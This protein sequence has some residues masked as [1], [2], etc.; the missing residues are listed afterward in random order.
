[1]SDDGW[2]D[3]SNG[4]DGAPASPEYAG[5]PAGT[6]MGS[7]AGTPAGTPTGTPIGSPAGNPSGSSSGT[8]IGSPTM[9]Y[10][11]G[12][13][14]NDG[15]GNGDGDGDGNN[16][17]QEGT[18]GEGGEGEGGG[19]EEWI[20]Y[21]DDE[22]KTYY[23]NA[24][25]QET[26]WDLPE[27]ATVVSPP[28]PDADVD[29]EAEGDAD[30]DGDGEVDANANANAEAGVDADANFKAE[31]LGDD[32]DT[33]GGVGAGA[34]SEQEQEWAKYQDD[35]GR[36]Y[37]YNATTG[38]TQWDM[39]DGFVDTPPPGGGVGEGEGDAAVTVKEE[40]GYT[41][42]PDGQEEDG[43]TG[44]PAMDMDVDVDVDVGVGVGVEA[45]A[46]IK[47]EDADARIKVEDGKDIDM[48]MDEPKPQPQPQVDIKQEEEE[49][50]K[51]EEEPPRDSQEGK[52]EHAKNALSQAD[53]ILEPDVAEHAF[54]VVSAGINPSVSLVKGYTG[55][56]AICGILSKWLL[57]LK[58]A[59]AVTD[60]KGTSKSTTTTTSKGASQSGKGG[61]LNSITFSK[62]GVGSGSSSSTNKKGGTDATSTG[63][64]KETLSIKNATADSIRQLVEK[65]IVRTAKTNFTEEVQERMVQ[66][67][68][69]FVKFAR[70][71][72]EMM[73]HSRWRR[74][75][76]DLAGMPQHKNSPFLKYCLEEI[77]K[78][79]HHREIAKRMNQSDYFDVF[80]R[81]VVNELTVLG[82]LS[83]NGGLKSEPNQDVDVVE[84]EQQVDLDLDMDVSLSTSI[85]NIVNDLKRQCTSTEYTYIYVIEVLDELI[86]RAKVKSKSLSGPKALGLL[87][88]I[89]K[90][91][92]LREEIEEHMIKP[93]N[94]NTLNPLARKR[95]VDIALT[96][97]E[98]YQRQRRRI[99]L[100][101]GNNKSSNIGS[102]NG[103]QTNVNSSEKLRYSVESGLVSTLKKY[104]MNVQMDAKLVEQL[105]YNPYKD[106][107]LSAEENQKQLG[108]QL[109]QHS[110][111][112]QYL[113]RCLFLPGS[114]VK[115]PELKMKCSRLIALAVLATETELI[116]MIGD[117]KNSNDDNNVDDD[118]KKKVDSG[119]EYDYKVTLL[120][121]TILVGSQLCEQV[122]SIVKFA[123]TEEV[124]AV[125]STSSVGTQLSAQ[126][127][128]CGTVAQGFLMWAKKR[129][130][131][132]DF[133]SSAAYPY[134]APGIL[135]LL[136]II[137]NRHPLLRETVVD[138]AL[139]FLD[140]SN[141]ELSY[142]KMNTIRE[143]ALRLLLIIAS[144]GLAIEVFEK[145]TLKLKGKSS[146][147]PGMVRYFVGGALEVMRPPFSLSVVRSM[148]TMLLM[149]PCL[150][151]LNAVYFESSKKLAFKKVIQSFMETVMK[152]RGNFSRSI[153]KDR[154]ITSALKS[155][156]PFVN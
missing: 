54:T 24:T 113:L 128:K 135:S 118:E 119:K 120:S 148:G 141:S 19:G 6:P 133:I 16:Q 39:P 121:K 57:D 83:I 45:G 147:D 116:E 29:V 40:D 136:R 146:F 110:L 23:Y 106:K 105:L 134:T 144:K 138:S 81:M 91:E 145:V 28:L 90:W 101:R 73:E 47:V 15:D 92:R 36:D 89:Q 149:K 79:G 112:T 109:S 142:Q 17:E 3:N 70:F 9:N 60:K 18:S 30:G 126:C 55:Q 88:A 12:D 130:S 63:T 38:V 95:R 131:N 102:S 33:D 103:L 115:S 37:Y 31:D 22:G 64:D 140:H 68:D 75:L 8:P 137:S 48:E 59:N 27:G 84:D 49:P 132:S 96:S 97:S 7:P 123:V 10:E 50:I 129:I 139:I 34:G 65:V 46:S 11:N 154:A 44:E 71:A 108:H 32:K 69:T 25:T 124:S 21:Q 82:K 156:Y 100:S 42:E 93:V 76:I 61:A 51:Q 80:H 150:G 74:L 99:R 35:D 67:K 20:E 78:R 58:V 143:Q 85:E 52:L 155:S 117:D 26:A 72:K 14:D 94:G 127:I 153:N 13:G 111:G 5:T 104:S 152:E 66:E 1:M 86:A 122:E 4:N 41:G 114:R 107:H 53:A 151:A 2:N 98:L 62:S 87:R 43:Y 56:T 125:S 77:S